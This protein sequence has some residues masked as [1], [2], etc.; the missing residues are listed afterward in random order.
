MSGRTWMKLQTYPRYTMG[1]LMWVSDRL[2]ISHLS[3]ICSGEFHRAE[4]VLAVRSNFGRTSIHVYRTKSIR[5]IFRNIS[6]IVSHLATSFLDGEMMLGTNV[7][8]HACCY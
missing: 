1:Q 7:Y 4:G 6:S 2:V 8:L 3:F 5:I